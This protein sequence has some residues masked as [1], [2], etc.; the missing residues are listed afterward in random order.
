M[1][2][3]RPRLKKAGNPYRFFHVYK[4]KRAAIAAASAATSIAVGLSQ[5]NMIKSAAFGGAAPKKLIIANAV[6]STYKSAIS[7]Y[8]AISETRPNLFRGIYNQKMKR[9]NG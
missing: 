2:I 7:S 6:I 4:A 3:I 1:K 5:I 8:K 9:V